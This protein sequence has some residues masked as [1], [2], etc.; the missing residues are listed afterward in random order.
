MT[1]IGCIAYLIIG[2]WFLFIIKGYGNILPPMRFVPADNGGY[3]LK[4]WIPMPL[5]LWNVVLTV[6]WLP[7][8][9]YYLIMILKEFKL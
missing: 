8:I 2:F 3:K 1:W 5:W 6:I 7:Y 4:E 9:I